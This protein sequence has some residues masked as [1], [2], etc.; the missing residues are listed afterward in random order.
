[1]SKTQLTRI[2]P[3]RPSDHAGLMAMVGALSARSRSMR[4]LSGGRTVPDEL[5][6]A[7]L[8][9]G[10]D[11]SPRRAWVA[12][13]PVA[14]LPA[15]RSLVG[16]ANWAVS[17]HGRPH[18]GSHDRGHGPRVVE[19]G[20]LVADEHQGR[21][22]GGRLLAAAA[23]DAWSA[24]AEAIR[25]D[26]HADNRRLLRRLRQGVPLLDA[27]QDGSM[28]SLVVPAAALL[29]AWMPPDEDPV[30]RTREPV[31]VGA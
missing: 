1:M 19:V 25:F 23:A 2:R 13:S 3:A 31:P 6:A 22:L 28:I 10:A 14:D 26:L 4:F 7:M 21:G 18:G 12:E 5:L 11:G 9:P 27:W 30:G 15:G 20:I 8:S 24:G 29:Q 16:H 17:A